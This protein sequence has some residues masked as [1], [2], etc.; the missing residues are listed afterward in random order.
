VC[1]SFTSAQKSRKHKQNN[2]NKRGDS[3]GSTN[4]SRRCCKK[5][6]RGCVGEIYIG[7]K[8]CEG[9]GIATT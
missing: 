2:P 5:L 9:K 4:K 3:P 1:E 7:F 6:E 8:K